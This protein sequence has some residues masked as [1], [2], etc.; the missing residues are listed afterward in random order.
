MTVL[1]GAVA[2][3]FPTTRVEE[4]TA[5][6]TEE[7]EHAETDLLTDSARSPSDS[8]PSNVGSGT[9]ET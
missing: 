3:R 4:S 9:R 1:T 7:V 5:E 2:G 6:L 8:K